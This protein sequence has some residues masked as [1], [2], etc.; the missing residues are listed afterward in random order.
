MATK[1]K[2]QISEKFPKA[3]IA[4]TYGTYRITSS[5]ENEQSVTITTMNTSSRDTTHI[6]NPSSSI[7]LYGTNISITSEN[8]DK[9]LY[10]TFET[11]K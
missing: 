3:I 2:W 11:V 7:D 5:E 10:G 9:K 6:L 4:S 8:L 1:G